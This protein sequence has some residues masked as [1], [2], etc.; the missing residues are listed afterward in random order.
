MTHAR[1]KLTLR[2]IG[3]LS[4][5]SSVAEFLDKVFQT[6]IRI[7]KAPRL[8]IDFRLQVLAMRLEPPIANLGFDPLLDPPSPAEFEGRLRARHAVVK[9]VLLDQSFAAGVGNWIADEILYQAGIDPRKRANELSLPEV[10]RVRKKLQDIISFAINVGA[11]DEKFPGTWLFHYRWG[12]KA[13]KDGRGKRIEF[14]TVGGRTTAWVP[15][16]IKN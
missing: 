14:I 7:G 3:R 6:F 2:F 15:G 11:D 16:A 8:H 4:L 1:Q 10:R 9:G 12:K 5:V 13:A